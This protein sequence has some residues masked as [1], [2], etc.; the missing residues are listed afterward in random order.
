MQKREE[1]KKQTRERILRAAAACFAEQ[2]YS[3]C[4]VSDIVDKA[5]VS[6]GA[7]Y[8]HFKTKEELFKEMIAIEHGMG[9]ERARQAVMKPPYL[10]GII[11]FHTECIQNSGFPMDHRL[12]AEVLAVAARDTEIREAFIASE[13][14]SRKVYME[15]LQKAADAGEI[16]K[17]LDLD[18]VSIWLYA[19]GDGMIIRIADDPTFD[20]K[21]Y[22][23]LFEIL[24]RRLLQL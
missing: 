3:G 2:G 22:H 7:L 9:I 23:A 17:S 21:K 14:T 13:R 11:W 24:I 15:L 18:A 1:K 4:S 19:L 16:D 10:S 20:F 6:K 8:V 5:G 12:W